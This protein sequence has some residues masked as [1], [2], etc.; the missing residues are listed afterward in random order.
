MDS[1]FAAD[2]SVGR[3][4]SQ[5]VQGSEFKKRKSKFFPHFNSK[6]EIHSSAVCAYTHT[7]R[8]AT[9]GSV[10]LHPICNPSAASRQASGNAAAIHVFHCFIHFA[11]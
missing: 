7:L 3:Y 1:V 6:S 11:D 8:W 9:T 5:S 2:M 10:T 4:E